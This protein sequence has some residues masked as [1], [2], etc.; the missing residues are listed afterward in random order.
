MSTDRGITKQKQKNKRKQ[1]QNTAIELTEI[2]LP[3][4]PEC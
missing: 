2:S 4:P 1:Q 3:M